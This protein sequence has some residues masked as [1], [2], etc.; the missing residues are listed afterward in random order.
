MYTI[1]RPKKVAIY[2]NSERKTIE[3]IKAETD[4][5]AVFNGALYHMPT[6]EPNMILKVDG[7]LLA[8]EPYAYL[9]YAWS[10]D[11][12]P[13]L[14]YDYDLY[15]NFIT[16]ANLVTDGKAG[17][18]YYAPE[19]NRVCGRTAMGM[20][21]DG[22]M[23]IYC[24]PNGSPYA[25][26]PIGLQNRMLNYGLQSAIMLDGGGSSQI[27]SKELTVKSDRIVQNLVLVWESKKIYRVQVGA[28][29][30]RAQAER[31]KEELADAGYSGFIVE[32][33]LP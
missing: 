7:K 14:T 3:Q 26:T 8:H 33:E 5:D 11:Q 29:P 16:G 21:A 2:V 13:V 10:G 28:F 22:R 27:I 32:A 17:E 30:T 1:L 31:D 6:Q 4:A 23:L 20:F 25:C 24:V 18:M 9:G 19:V 15:Q 12:L